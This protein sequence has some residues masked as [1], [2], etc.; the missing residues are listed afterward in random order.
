M[1]E[2]TV[3]VGAMEVAPARPGSASGEAH[4]AGLRLAGH[5]SAGAQAYARAD[6]GIPAA[7]DAGWQR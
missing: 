3:G 1:S 2:F 5:A 7:S 6:E 4:D